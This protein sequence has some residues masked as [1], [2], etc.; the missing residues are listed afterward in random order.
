MN[1]ILLVGMA[2]GLTGC[3]ESVPI[4]HEFPQ[5]IPEIMAAC[6][7]LSKIP[8][9]TDK[10]SD[11]VS[12]VTSNY[13]EYHTCRAKVDAWVEWYTEQKKIYEEAQQ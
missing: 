8:L 7:E 4:K 12:V 10:L 9:G 1:K 13:G 11:L 5:A 3:L 2:A 6:P